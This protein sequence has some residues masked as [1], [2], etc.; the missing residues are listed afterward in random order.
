MQNYVGYGFNANDIPAA[1]LL[2]LMK[3]YDREAYDEYVEDTKQW[4]AESQQS[5]EILGND[6]EADETGNLEK[7]LVDYILERISEISIGLPEYVG[8]IINK[9]ES[10]KAGTDN[11]VTTYDNYIVFDS[12]R[13]IGDDK[14]AEYIR[15]QDD[16]I[17]MI[18]RYITV[19]GIHFG[20]LYE[21]SDW[22][23][24]VYCLE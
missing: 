8:A 23:D 22:V 16:F 7:A 1:D 2:A 24:P 5:A 6:S 9:A 21:G 17:I 19:K 3:K 4:L 11:L 20:N 12:I 14:R 13:F 10:E 15:D 18:S